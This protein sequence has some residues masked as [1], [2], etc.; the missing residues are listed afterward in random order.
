MYWLAVTFAAK[1]ASIEVLS[2]AL[3]EAG[4]MSVDVTDAY[5]GT[6]QEIV[7]ADGS[8]EGWVRT[9]DGVIAL[10]EPVP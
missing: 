7:D 4:A 1:A 6:P 8:T 10:G 5:A 3:Q 9:D 2:D